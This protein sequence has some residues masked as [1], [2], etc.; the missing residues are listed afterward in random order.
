ML[1]KMID[2]YKG[3]LSEGSRS[4]KSTSGSARPIEF[5]LKQALK[6]KWRYPAE[7]RI[8][9]VKPTIPLG[10]Q[11]LGTVEGAFKRLN[12]ARTAR[13][14][15]A[16]QCLQMVFGHASDQ[17]LRALLAALAQLAGSVEP[18]VPSQPLDGRQ[19]VRAET[20]LVEATVSASVNDEGQ[21]L[22]R[23]VL[24]DHQ[25]LRLRH[26]EPQKAGYLQSADVRHADIKENEVRFQLTCLLKRLRPILSLPANVP[27]ALLRQNVDDA[28]TNDVAIVRN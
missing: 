4:G 2:G 23:I 5:V 15:K 22:S 17:G 24:A 28:A 19:Q 25:D 12:T 16:Q 6:R 11:F 10:E 21:Q 13:A 3:A 7:E 8:E 26:F 1:E 9:D 18:L 27:F 20:A 14:Y